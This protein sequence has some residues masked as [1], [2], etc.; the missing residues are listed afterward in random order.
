LIDRAGLAAAMPETSLPYRPDAPTIAEL[1]AGVVVFGPDDGKVF[2]LHHRVQDRWCLP[3]GHVDPGE[4]LATAALRET[5]EEAG[6]SRVELGEEICEVSYRYFE[7][8]RALNVVK[9]IV[10]FRGRTSEREPHLEE[11]FDRSEWTDL[12]SA[13]DRVRYDADKNVLRAAGPR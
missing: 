13:V 9:V 4:S 5:R 2:L 6:F 10:Y 11:T 1:A 3:K 8:K 7:P 12:A